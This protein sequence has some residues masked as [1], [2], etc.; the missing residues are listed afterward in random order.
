MLSICIPTFNRAATLAR[1]LAS[2]QAQ[3][4]AELEIVVLDNHSTDDT[5]ALVREAARS[6]ERIRF[7]RH[8]ENVGLGRNF[9]AC[10]GEAR[11]ELVKLLCD[12]D[13][14]ERDCVAAL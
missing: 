6:D 13:W 10:I 5:E 9:S 7:V 11:G 3:T 8:A 14:L 1:A 12:D 2:A 4:F